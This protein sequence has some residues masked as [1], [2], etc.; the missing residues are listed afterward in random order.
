MDKGVSIAVNPD[1]HSKEGIQD[2]HFGVLAARKG[3]L[4]KEGCLNTLS[5]EEFSKKIN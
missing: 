1:A 2:I 4:T 5:L 3:L